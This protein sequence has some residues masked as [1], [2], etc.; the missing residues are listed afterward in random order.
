MEIF[1]ETIEIALSWQTVRI[2]GSFFFKKKVLLC[3][4]FLV[5]EERFLYY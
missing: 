1:S 5:K 3:H 4:V 2:V